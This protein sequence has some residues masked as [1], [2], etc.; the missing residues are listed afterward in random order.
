MLG[1]YLGEGQRGQFS[2]FFSL[3]L[4]LIHNVSLYSLALSVSLSYTFF[5][6]LCIFLYI[7]S[8]LPLCVSLSYTCFLSLCLLYVNL[9][10]TLSLCVCFSLFPLA[11]Y[12]YF[13]LFPLLFY[14]YFSLF[15]SLFSLPKFRNDMKK[16][17]KLIFP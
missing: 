4:S 5:F 12:F 6:S 17:I 9:S 16:L 15:F 1:A 13:S 8:F 3:P 14:F 7:S 11:F 10:L 2:V